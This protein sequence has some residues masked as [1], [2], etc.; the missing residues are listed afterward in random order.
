[1]RQPTLSGPPVRP[2]PVCAS[3]VQLGQRYLHGAALRC[4]TATTKSAR[5]TLTIRS[6]TYTDKTLT[7][8]AVESPGKILVLDTCHF[9]QLA[10]QVVHTFGFT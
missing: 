8:F 3:I 10:L 5:R 2:L 4:Q 1:M 9:A 7:A 6:V